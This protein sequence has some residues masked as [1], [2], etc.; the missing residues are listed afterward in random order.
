MGNRVVANAK[1][2]FPRSQILGIMIFYKINSKGL[3]SG[4]GGQV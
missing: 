4:F 2:K 1:S 3:D